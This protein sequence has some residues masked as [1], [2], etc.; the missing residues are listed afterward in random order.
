MIYLSW[1]VVEL[2]THLVVLLAAYSGFMHYGSGHRKMISTVFTG[3][4]TLTLYLAF[5]VGTRQQDLQRSSFD[6]TVPTATTDKVERVTLNRND[7]KQTFENTVKE[8]N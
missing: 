4:L 8:T 3:L 1:S 2:I 6:A 7:V 5:D